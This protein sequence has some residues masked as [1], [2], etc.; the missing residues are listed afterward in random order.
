MKKNKNIYTIEAT[1]GYITDT[2]MLARLF[3]NDGYDIVR[4]FDKDTLFAQFEKQILHGM[5]QPVR[6]F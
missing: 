4:F 6:T 3:L 2:Y 5:K 1:G